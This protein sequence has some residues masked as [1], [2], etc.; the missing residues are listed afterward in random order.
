MIE[1]FNFKKDKKLLK[2]LPFRHELSIPFLDFAGY[3]FLRNGEKIIAT[4]DILY[5][6]E[7]PYLYLP[8]KKINWENSHILWISEK[9]L[10]QLK[11]E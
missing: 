5:P 1:K 6:N 7:F 8:K 10:E 4:Q 3:V 9:E 11:K 2:N